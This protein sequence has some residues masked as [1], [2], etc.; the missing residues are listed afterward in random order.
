MSKVGEWKWEPKDVTI[1]SWEAEGVL[2]SPDG[3]KSRGNFSYTEQNGMDWDFDNA[4]NDKNDF[5]VDDWT[6][7]IMSIHPEVKP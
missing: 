7:F 2:T 3:K 1:T 4:P 5:D 6:D